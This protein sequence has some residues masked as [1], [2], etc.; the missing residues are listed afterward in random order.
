MNQN[1]RVV[2][3]ERKVIPKLRERGRHMGSAYIFSIFLL[4]CKAHPTPRHL[5][6]GYPSGTLRLERRFLWNTRPIRGSW[7]FLSGIKGHKGNRYS[8]SYFLSTM[9]IAILILALALSAFAQSNCPLSGPYECTGGSINGINFGD[10]AD[11]DLFRYFYT[12]GDSRSD[13]SCTTLQEGTYVVDGATVSVEFEIDDDECVITG[14]DG[15][16]CGCVDDM[17]LTVTSEDCFTISGPNGETCV[18]TST[19]DEGFTCSNGATP[20]EDP[21]YT[22]DSN[23]CGPSA[24]PIAGPSFGFESCCEEHDICYGSCGTSRT[25]CDNDFYSCM[26]CICQDEGNFLD[27]LPF[28]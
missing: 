19:C 27:H 2:L 15:A 12:I 9:K 20:T 6:D 14:S 21:N 26:Y 11:D 18:A 17:T 5:P 22:A 7:N 3:K 10:D 4:L 24:F 25:Q 16:G 23:G 1:A 8:I 13:N 28:R